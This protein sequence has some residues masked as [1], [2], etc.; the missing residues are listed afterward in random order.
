[1]KSGKCIK[2]HSSNVYVKAYE[3]NSILINGKQVA[4]ESYIC[5]DCGY[6]ETYVTDK[7]ALGKIVARVEKIGDWK[8]VK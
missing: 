4:N 7:D 5:A 2:C 8:K 1:M 6:F 3:I